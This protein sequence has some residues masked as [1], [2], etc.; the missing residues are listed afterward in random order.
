MILKW[1]RMSLALAFALVLATVAAPSPAVATSR[2]LALGMAVSGASDPATYDALKAQLGRAP[3]LWSIMSVWGSLANPDP[4]SPF[5][6]STLSWLRAPQRGSTPLIAWEP[7]DRTNPY[8]SDNPSN[9]S[10]ITSGKYDAYIRQWASAA[11]EY[12]HRVI[13]RF[14]PELDGPWFPW[15][16]GVHTNTPAKLVKAWRHVWGI[17]HAVGAKNVKFLWNPIAA[18][19]S[20]EFGGAPSYTLKD[21]YPGDKYVDYVSFSG[22]NWYTESDPPRSWR[23]MARVYGERY[24]W[25]R[26]VTTKRKMIIPETGTVSGETP[27]AKAAWISQGYRAVYK[28]FPAIVAI[29]YFNV[30]A[31][32]VG[33]PDWRL[34]VTDG[35]LAAYKA[36]LTKHKFQGTLK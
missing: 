14:A 12:G 29:V 30:D 5:P 6:I 18:S 27:R 10:Q 16:V 2:Q 3:A 22:Y 20:Y 32:M 13:L 1:P 11:K 33:Q 17:F 35:S 15:G 28:R 21:L 24:A 23:T 19:F 7:V 8:G 36:L 9:L 31:S 4:S 34:S 26:R 25:I